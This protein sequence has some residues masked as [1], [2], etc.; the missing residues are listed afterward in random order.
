RRL[1][2]IAR[3]SD[4]FQS[5]LQELKGDLEHLSRTDPLTG[6]ANRRDIRERLEAEQSRC[7][8]NG[9]VFSLIMADFD[10]FKRIND[11]YGHA[12][13]DNFLVAVA[14]TFQAN[15]RKEDCCARWGGEEFLILLPETEPENAV[16]TAEKLR[17]II[18]GYALEL[19]G[20]AIGATLSFGIS[21]YRENEDIDA[22]IAKADEA[23]YQAKNRG[24]NQS[25]LYGVSV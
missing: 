5:E 13:G 21:T 12:A 2:R 19:Q 4:A 20:N 6:L 9:K 18:A 3:I 22:C 1:A 7:H 24:R 10:Y 8:R 14:Q 16:K 17:K 11:K 23:L 15:L 25:V